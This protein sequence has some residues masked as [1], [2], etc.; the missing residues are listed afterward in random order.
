[1]GVSW[2]LTL[3]EQYRLCENRALKG[4][5]GS[6][7]EEVV[8]CWKI[9]H[10][11]ELNNLYTSPNIILVIKVKEDEIEYVVRMGEMRNT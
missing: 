2:S 3:R 10:E 4:I 8:G 7:R 9:L 1:M 11:K 5:F 6:K